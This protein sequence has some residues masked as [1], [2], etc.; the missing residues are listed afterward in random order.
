[1]TD[2]PKINYN[3]VQLLMVQS[4]TW[5]SDSTGLYLNQNLNIIFEGDGADAHELTL[6]N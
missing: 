3:L 2:S 6:D 1:M 4:I 5:S